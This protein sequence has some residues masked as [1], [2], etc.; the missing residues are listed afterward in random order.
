M[1][2]QFSLGKNSKQQKNKQ[3]FPTSMAAELAASNRVPFTIKK[4]PKHIL[5]AKRFSLYIHFVGHAKQA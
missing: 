2:C 3:S 4:A 1:T 5:R